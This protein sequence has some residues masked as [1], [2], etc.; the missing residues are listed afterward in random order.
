MSVANVIRS[1]IAR[2]ILQ[3][4]DERTLTDAFP[5]IDEH[6]L[7]SMDIQRLVGFLETEFGI[8]VTDDQLLP[9]NFATIAA[10]AAMVEALRA[11]RT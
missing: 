6:V 5:L 8:R 10:M 9:D 1:F 2:E 4:R 7:D 11:A 3:D